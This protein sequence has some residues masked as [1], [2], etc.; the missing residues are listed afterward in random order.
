MRLWCA[1]RVQINESRYKQTPTKFAGNSETGR[2]TFR[3]FGVHL[4][5][6]NPGPEL[7]PDSRTAGPYGNQTRTALI[8]VHGCVQFCC[9]PRSLRGL[10]VYISSAERQCGLRH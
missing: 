7:D 8:V 3:P 6:D 10:L 4:N 9:R 2:R 5:A 1:H